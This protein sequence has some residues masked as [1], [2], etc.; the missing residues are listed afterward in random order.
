MQDDD[1]L[2]L[3]I[4]LCRFVDKHFVAYSPAAPSAGPAASAGRDIRRRAQPPRYGSRARRAD[5][6]IQQRGSRGHSFG[7]LVVACAR[8]REL[9]PSSRSPAPPGFPAMIR[10]PARAVAPRRAALR[11]EK[12]ARFGRRGRKRHR[13]GGC[14]AVL[15]GEPAVA[16]VALFLLGLRA[17]G[18]GAMRWTWGGRSAAGGRWRRGRGSRALL[19]HRYA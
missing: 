11:L 9:H 17:V 1:T 15:P 12:A 10:P 14:W 18:S 5:C 4:C 3:V 13:L 19:R 2:S 7:P 16:E 8:A 6:A